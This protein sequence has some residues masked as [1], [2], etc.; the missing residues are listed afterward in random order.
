MAEML[1]NF[2]LPEVQLSCEDRERLANPGGPEDADIGIILHVQ[3]EDDIIDEFWDPRSATIRLLADKRING[4]FCLVLIG[5]LT[6]GTPAT[7]RDRC[8]S[9]AAREIAR[10]LLCPFSASVYPPYIP[11][12]PSPA[13]PTL[14][15]HYS[16]KPPPPRHPHNSTP[17]FTQRVLEQLHNNR[18]SLND[19]LFNY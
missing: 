9:A 11:H 3:S 1:E 2:Y 8:Q 5:T 10:Y 15:M 12:P 6:G 13:F 18:D 4:S 19:Y 17:N 7:Q 14:I 16:L